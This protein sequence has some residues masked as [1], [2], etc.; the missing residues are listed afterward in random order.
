MCPM[1]EMVR[2]F[3]VGTT[4]EPS[5]PGAVLLANDSGDAR[6]TMRAHVDDADQRPVVLVWLRSWAVRMEPTNDEA[7]TGHPLYRAG[8]RDVLWVGEVLQSRLIANL[9]KRNRFHALHD[10]H[11][12]RQ[13]RHWVVPLKEVLVE[14]VAESIELQR[15]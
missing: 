2:N 15:G 4:W 14:V 8:L 5:S 10:P 1:S 6:L 13:L 12:F 11:R 3:D 7:L 9:E